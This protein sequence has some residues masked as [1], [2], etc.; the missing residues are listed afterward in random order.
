MAV[1]SD[2]TK[3]DGWVIGR[4]DVRITKRT[5]RLLG[6]SDGERTVCERRRPRDFDA[7]S[8]GQGESEMEHCFSGRA[9]EDPW[10]ISMAHYTKR[11]DDR[12]YF[13]GLFDND[14]LRHAMLAN[15][16]ARKNIAQLLFD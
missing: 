10:T 3:V 9:G 2:E 4:G 13:H 11:M 16:A 1:E 6:A 5:V 15:L 8:H 14:A 12:T 7:N